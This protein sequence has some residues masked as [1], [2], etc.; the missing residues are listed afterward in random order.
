M[1]NL[2]LSDLKVRRFLR[3]SLAIVQEGAVKT[4][5][6]V[7]NNYLSVLQLRLLLV[8][9][10]VRN[11]STLSQFGTLTLRSSKRL[12]QAKTLRVSYCP[13]SH[14]SR[15]GSTRSWYTCSAQFNDRPDYW[16]LSGCNCVSSPAWK[17]GVCTWDVIGLP[18]LCV[19]VKRPGALPLGVQIIGAPYSEA[20]ILRVAAVL[21]SQGIISAE[22]I[23]H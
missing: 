1:I 7:Q 3:N 18:V 10:F 6:D 2:T 14:R 9:A 22:S 17:T 23:S 12:S 16:Q 21:E 20:V 13:E 5:L 19:P 8:Y 11:V 15:N 4:P